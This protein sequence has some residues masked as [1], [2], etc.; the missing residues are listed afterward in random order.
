MGHNEETFGI[1]IQKDCKYEYN[2]WSSCS[3]RCGDGVK[4]GFLNIIQ[5]PTYQGEACP[6]AKIK[7][8]PCTGDICDIDCSGT[9]SGWSECNVECGSGNQTNTFTMVTNYSYQGRRC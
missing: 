4:I 8:E 5:Q 7:T 3:Q 2:R 6:T 1:D 9:W